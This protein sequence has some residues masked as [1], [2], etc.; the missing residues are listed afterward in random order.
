LRRASS[1]KG[2][3]EP[4]AIQASPILAL[5]VAC[6]RFARLRAES[7]VAESL[8]SVDGRAEDDLLQATHERLFQFLVPA[9]IAFGE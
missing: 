2:V 7:E 8:L 3:V 1:K 5:G 6:Q 9:A 4:Q